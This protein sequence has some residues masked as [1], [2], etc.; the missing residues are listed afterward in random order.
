MSLRLRC[1]L[2]SEGVQETDFIHGPTW[3]S[4]SPRLGPRAVAPWDQPEPGV[5][6]S[7]VGRRQRKV[8]AEPEDGNCRGLSARNGNVEQSPQLPLDARKRR[9]GAHRAHLPLS[10]RLPAVTALSSANSVPARQSQ[11]QAARHISDGEQ[12]SCKPCKLKPSPH[13]Q[14]LAAVIAPRG[15]L[16]GSAVLPRSFGLA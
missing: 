1:L 16:T 2:R 10:Y 4:N 5:A 8:R 11:T 3:S 9:H 14:D 6:A 12:I 15:V 13:R 7:P